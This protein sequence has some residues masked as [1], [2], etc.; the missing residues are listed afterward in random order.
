MSANW[1]SL[2]ASIWSAKNAVAKSPGSPRAPAS[3]AAIPFGQRHLSRQIEPRRAQRHKVREALGPIGPARIRRAGERGHGN[4]DRA[5]GAETMDQN[6]QVHGNLRSKRRDPREQ[7]GRRQPKPSAGTIARHLSTCT[8]ARAD[9]RVQLCAT[10]KRHASKMH[11]ARRTCPR[12]G[13]RALHSMLLSD[14]R[15]D[16]V[17]VTPFAFAVHGLR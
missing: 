9:G 3:R 1:T 7:Q 11:P 2:L 10:A 8:V 15:Q 4:G 13:T 12:C 5:S 14:A 17:A 16:R 6:A